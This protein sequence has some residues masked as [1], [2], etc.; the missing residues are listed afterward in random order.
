M[1]DPLRDLPLADRLICALDVDGMEAAAA[2]VQKLDGVISFFKVG[3]LLHLAAGSDILRFL[4]ERGKRVFLDLKYYDIPETVEKAV[5]HAARLGISFLTI[6]G[7]T[8]IIEHA[9]AARADSQLRLLAVTALTSLDEADIKA[10]GYPCDV[11]ELVMS[12]VRAAASSGCD[13][14]VCSPQE[15]AAIRREV[16]NDLIVV[17]PGIRPAASDKGEHKRLAGPADAIRAGSDFL[18]VGRPILEAPD[19]RAAAAAIIRE[20]ETG[21]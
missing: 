6:H 7:N 12:R 19:P 10:M 21:A 18:V 13:G 14:V 8:R 2:M 16:G 15:I 1:T 20:M 5:A 4:L 3:I 17:T 11:A 9:V